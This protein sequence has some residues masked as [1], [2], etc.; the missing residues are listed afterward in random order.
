MPKTATWPSTRASAATDIATGATALGRVNTRV[1]IGS[2]RHSQY[3]RLLFNAK[4]LEAGD[5]TAGTE[6]LRTVRAGCRVRRVRPRAARRALAS[7]PSLVGDRA[8]EPGHGAAAHSRRHGSVS[9]ARG[10]DRGMRVRLRRRAPVAGGS[11]RVVVGSRSAAP[12][13]AA[14]SLQYRHDETLRIHVVRRRAGGVRDS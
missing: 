3:R 4:H 12:H 9:A 5:E 7:E 10:T 2:L 11:L 6:D 13:L 1:F 8:G 14:A